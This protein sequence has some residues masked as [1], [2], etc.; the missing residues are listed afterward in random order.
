ESA[1]A[2]RCGQLGTLVY[3]RGSLLGYFWRCLGGSGGDGS[4]PLPRS[5]RAGDFAITRS[6][7]GRAGDTTI[8]LPL[9]G[10][11]GV[12]GCLYL[13]AVLRAPVR[14][15]LDLGERRT[16]RD[17]LSGVGKDLGERAIGGRGYLRVHLVR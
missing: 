6:L 4:I 13:L 3:I 11:A 17:R 15:D 5:A 12:G 1:R 8:F 7:R 16:D 14:S 9:W 10:R 2:G